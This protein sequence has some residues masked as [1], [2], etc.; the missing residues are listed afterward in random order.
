V[1]NK[2]SFRH[3]LAS[4]LVV[5]RWLL[6]VAI[7]A[8]IAIEIAEVYLQKD[9]Y[10]LAVSAIFFLLANMQIGISRL[11]ISMDDE[12]MSRRFFYLSIVMLCAA[13]IAVFDMGIDRVLAEMAASQFAFLY[14][15]VSIA[16]FLLGSIS[17]LLAGYSLD[18][19]F[20]LIRRKIVDLADVKL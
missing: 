2:L 5:L 4:I 17:T 6:W 16:E 9:V 13:V 3:L 12:E 10:H 14:K 20:V 8:N 19:F 1:Q 18:R 7:G 15:L 11:L